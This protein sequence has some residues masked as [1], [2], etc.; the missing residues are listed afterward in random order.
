MGKQT[1]LGLALRLARI[2]AG[3]SQWEIASKVGSHQSVVNY[4][5]TGKQVKPELARACL[6][7]C[8]AAA[9]RSPFAQ[10]V[11]REARQVV[12]AAV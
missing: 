1:D 7:A 8:A 6:A 3:M 5:E 9:P 11:L 2:V 10:A 4:L 12:E